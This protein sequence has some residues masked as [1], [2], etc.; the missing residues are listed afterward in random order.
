M[1]LA[2]DSV[3]VIL[4]RGTR[5]EQPNN[6]RKN[7][8]IMWCNY[9]LPFGHW[10]YGTEILSRLLFNETSFVLSLSWLLMNIQ[11]VYYI[12]KQPVKNSHIRHIYSWILH[13]DIPLLVMMSVTNK[14]PSSLTLSVNTED[15]GRVCFAAVFENVFLLLSVSSAFPSCPLFLR[16]TYPATGRSLTLQQHS[17]SDYGLSVCRVMRRFVV[18][19]LFFSWLFYVGGYR[20]CWI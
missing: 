13:W 16:K 15:W 8:W 7:F 11:P 14:Q 20:V 10:R 12:F 4:A 5:N 6:D 19:L 2:P 17:I 9:F 3:E 18:L 1:P